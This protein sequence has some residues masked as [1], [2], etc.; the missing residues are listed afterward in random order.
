MDCYQKENV[1]KKTS[2]LFPSVFPTF[3]L[4]NFSSFAYSCDS[5]HN[6]SPP[7]PATRMPERSLRTG[8][9]SVIDK[10]ASYHPVRV[11]GSA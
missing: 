1:E 6:T 3:N 10:L 8:N 9:R 5:A 7:H 4:A 2:F 11:P